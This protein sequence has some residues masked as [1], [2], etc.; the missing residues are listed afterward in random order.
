[1]IAKSL[2]RLCVI[3]LALAVAG[4]QSTTVTKSV[5][6]EV[7]AVDAAANQFK[8]KGD[9][10]SSYVVVFDD[11]TS[12]LRLPLGE[13][14]LKKAEKITLSAITIGDRLLARERPPRTPSPQP[15]RPS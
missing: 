7:T 1:M 6:G 14:D 4:A 2:M 8:I 3:L 5:V 11:A 15:P 12:Y 9:D 13:K 10:G